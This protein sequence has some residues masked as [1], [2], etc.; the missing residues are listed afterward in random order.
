VVIA[1]I[2]VNTAH[3]LADEIGDRAVAAFYDATDPASVEEAI[4]S[5]VD[6]QGRL[7]IL[8]NNHADIE[9]MPFD[10]NPVDIGLEVWDKVMATNLRGYLLGCRFAI[11]HLLAAGQSSIINTASIGGLMGGL[12][13]VAYGTSKGGI[14]SL[15]RMIATKYG[16]QGLRCNAIAP[17][18][19]VT[20]AL[21]RVDSAIIA[22]MLRHTVIGRTGRPEDIANLACFLA[23]EESGFI[24]GQVITIDGGFLM[25]SPT[26]ADEMDALLGASD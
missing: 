18:L 20:P 3:N 25:K 19:I 21:E 4:R 17:G 24:T 1:D 23:S 9:T 22:P 15:T 12:G 2:A 6:N 13:L 8:H 11:P 5:T 16:R 26:F 10:T 7:D 14:L